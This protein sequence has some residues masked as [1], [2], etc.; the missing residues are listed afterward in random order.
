MS[1]LSREATII[2]LDRPQDA[3][4]TRDTEAAREAAI[5]ARIALTW[6][7]VT[8]RREAFLIYGRR[9]IPIRDRFLNPRRVRE[10]NEYLRTHDLEVKDPQWRSNAIWLAE[11]WD[12]LGIS[13]NDCP[14][15]DP[16]D[17]RKWLRVGSKHRTTGSGQEE[18]YTPKQYIA[19]AREVMGGIDLDPATS[20]VA[21]RTVGA[22]R[23]FTQ[24]EDGLSHDWP[25]R[26]WL[27][28][29][30]SKQKL[31]LFTEHLVTQITKGNTTAAIALTHAYTDTE[32]FAYLAP[33]MSALCLTTGRVYFLAPSG[34]AG[35][36]PTQGQAFFYYGE[37]PTEFARV[38]GEFGIILR[39]WERSDPQV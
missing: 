33:V 20:L 30:Y 3:E 38:F 16:G 35:K 18:W 9:L 11:N 34:D 36:R 10:Y 2:R 15:A 37:E 26:V 5:V 7:S 19:A 25:G 23:Y 24:E 32:W 6:D 31:A 8:T 1:E 4:L 13:L 28:P 27:N 39:S 17:I 12:H 22:A 21:Q 14:Y 29:P